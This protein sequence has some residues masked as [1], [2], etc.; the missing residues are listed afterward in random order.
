MGIGKSVALGEAGCRTKTGLEEGTNLVVN[1]QCAVGK[2]RN[3]FVSVKLDAV[4]WRP[5]R[6]E[7][8]CLVGLKHL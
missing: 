1:Q 7:P 6:G 5:W 8:S 2:E 3:V 4:L